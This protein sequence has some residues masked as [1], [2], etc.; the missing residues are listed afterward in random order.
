MDIAQAEPGTVPFGRDTAPFVDYFERGLD[1][2]RRVASRGWFAG[3]LEALLMGNSHHKDWC[4]PEDSHLI[5]DLLCRATRAQ[6]DI[7]AFCAEYHSQVRPSWH[8]LGLWRVPLESIA[9]LLAND[10]LEYRP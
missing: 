3:G 4:M 1:S 8:Y 10:L 9:K 7:L 6:A 5:E 2:G